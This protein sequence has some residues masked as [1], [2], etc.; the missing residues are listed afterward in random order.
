MRRHGGA[1]NV[2]ISI[3][4][5][6]GKRRT[7]RRRTPRRRHWRPM[8]AQ[9]VKASV[10]NVVARPVAPAAIRASTNPPR[11]SQPLR[12]PVELIRPTAKYLDQRAFQMPLLNFS[13]RQ[14]RSAQTPYHAYNEW[15]IYL[16]ATIPIR[17][18]VSADLDGGIVL[19]LRCINSSRPV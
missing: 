12:E 18:D 4:T 17:S 11:R 2:R 13:T 14:Y 9:G 8:A 19:P 1:I 6:I 15:E 5:I 10:A 7:P 3:K 16:A